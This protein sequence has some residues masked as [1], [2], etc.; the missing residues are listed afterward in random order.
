M[1]ITAEQTKN[2]SGKIKLQS[3]L[4]PSFLHQITDTA[5]CEQLLSCI[6]CGTCSAT[7]PL[8]D[9][10]D[11]TPRRIIGMVRE[12][13]KKEV[14]NSSTIWL[15]ASCYSCTVE[16]PRE[17]KI[18]DLMYALKREAIVEKTYP[19][20]FPIPV[21]ASAFFNQVKRHGRQN[22]TRL[23]MTM[24]LLTNPFRLLKNTR[25]ALRMF[26]RGRLSIFEKGIKDTKGLQKLLKAVENK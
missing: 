9:R 1:P 18:T 20:R 10:M 4:D 2:G 13:F 8:S 21:L 22:E 3:D 17:I 14:L 11:Y 25:L 7:C 23:I 12:G 24:Y 5:Q 16:C 26:L 19:K 15:C 6:Q